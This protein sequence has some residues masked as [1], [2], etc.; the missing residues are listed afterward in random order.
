[1]SIKPWYEVVKPREDLREG[2]P[3]DASEFAVHLDHIVEGRAEVHED[4][5]DPKRFFEKTFLTKALTQLA[6]DV[7]RRLSSVTVATSAVYNMSTQ[8]GGGKTHALTLLYHLA[9][10]GNKAKDWLGVDKLLREAE[11][12]NIPLANTAVFVGTEFDSITGRGG[13]DGTPVRKTPW[14]DIAFQ[15][16]GSDGYLRL[17]E[18]DKTGTA[19]GGD[20]L[21]DLFS[22][23]KPTLI[24]M[25]EVLNY[26]NRSRKSGLGSQFYTFLHNLTE[27]ARGEKNVILVVSIP[28]SLLEM[29]VEDEDDFNR[30]KKMLD[31]VGRPIVISSESETSEIIRRRLFEWDT[32]QLTQSG[33]I[34]LNKDSIAACKEYSNWL[35][36]NKH[37]IPGWFA[38]DEAEEQFKATYPFHPMVLSVFERKW[39]SLP[40]FQQTRGVLR[41]LAQWVSIIYSKGF[42]KA[43]K[44][45]LINLGTAPLDDQYFRRT[46]F[47]Q[48]GEDKLDVAVI[49]DINGRNDSFALRLDQQAAEHIKKSEMHQKIASAIFFESSGGQRNHFATLPEIRLSTTEPGIEIGNIETVLDELSSNCYYLSINKNEYSFSLS[50]NLN[51][52]L[53]DRRSSIL[54]KAIHERIKDVI[55][56]VI[57]EKADINRVFYPENSV[58]IAD[59]P[60]LT[61]VILSPEKKISLE[62]TKVFVKSATNEHGKS[63]RTFKTALIWCIPDST[64]NLIDSA[65]KVLA[66]ED[67]KLNDYS[68]LNSDQTKELD[69]NL[70]K[71]IRDLTESVWRSYKTIAYLGIGNEIEYVDLG[72]IHSSSAENLLSLV[73]AKL[74]EVD[75][76]T[77]GINP[78]LLVRNW[79][80][81][82]TEWSTKALRDAIYASPKLPRLLSPELLRSTI[83]RGVANGIFAYVGKD[84]DWEYKPFEFECDIHESQIE[85]SD[86]MYII[87]AETARS[88]FEPPRLTYLEL[89]PSFADLMPNEEMKFNVS[90][91]DQF[92]RPFDTAFTLWSAESGTISKDGLYRA[93]NKECVDCISV[94]CSNLKQTVNIRIVMRDTSKTKTEVDKKTSLHWSGEIQHQKWMNF[95][96]KVL[97]KY[98]NSPELKIRIDLCI[99][100]DEISEQ[101]IEETKSSLRDLGMNDVVDIK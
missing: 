40:R 84:V 13:K 15:L 52:I 8:F 57:G 100:S 49:T 83:V 85:I 20:V 17:Q 98:A 75:V 101:K 74:I 62:D 55:P 21:R 95:Y 96:T 4:Y 63:G 82:K 70:K 27:V 87:T 14:G 64:S 71:S 86:D 32:T 81:T 41:M 18:H 10:N 46:V 72:L 69:T 26:I 90:G 58:D 23:S 34:S 99:K 3:L 36:E 91:K 65:R 25:D 38:I 24:L 89:I 68:K 53:S 47:E 97:S 2:K 54:P 37:Q 78:S 77:K 39:Q 92:S 1:M 59:R 66:W 51:K 44:D 31:R 61:A 93:P 35:L 30:I 28:A 43:S 33:K 29:S 42:K 50:P 76:V 7:I 12:T 79:P 6:S 56:K 19:P 60:L 48:L 22:D 45:Y 16:K 9:K 67:I 94:E 73:L 80:P 5:K 11:T 88:S